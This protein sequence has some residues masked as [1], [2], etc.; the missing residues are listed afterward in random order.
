MTGPSRPFDPFGS[1]AAPPTAEAK[2]SSNATSA[3]QQS[4]SPASSPK[5]SASLSP[6]GAVAD[7]GTPTAA[8]ATVNPTVAPFISPAAPAQTGGMQ[9]GRTSIFEIGGEPF[10]KNP[11]SGSSAK[12]SRAVGTANDGLLSSRTSPVGSHPLGTIMGSPHGLFNETTYGAAHNQL[13]AAA[14][15]RSTA[16][17]PVNGLHPSMHRLSQSRFGGGLADSSVLSS[18]SINRGGGDGDSAAATV[19]PPPVLDTSNGLLETMQSQQASP[20]GTAQGG[21][22]DFFVK[23]L[24]VSRRNSREFQNLWQELE[25]F[26]IN[27]NSAHVP[28]FDGLASAEP[29][30]LGTSPKLPQGLL[31]DDSLAVRPRIASDAPEATSSGNGRYNRNPGTGRLRMG[32]TVEFGTTSLLSENNVAAGSVVSGNTFAH[33][34]P[35]YQTYAHDAAARGYDYNGAPLP[36]KQPHLQPSA[37]VDTMHGNGQHGSHFYDTS[38]SIGLIRNASTPVLNTKQYQSMQT[39][40]DLTQAPGAM[41]NGVQGDSE[42][43]YAHHP[44][45]AYSG[46]GGDMSPFDA[47]GARLPQNMPSNYPHAANG[48]AMASAGRNQPFIAGS[49]ASTPRTNGYGM[50][51]PFVPTGGGGA[52]GLGSQSNGLHASLQPHP[53][54]AASHIHIHT[55]PSMHAKPLA[56]RHAQPPQHQH[57]VSTTALSSMG[58]TQ[59]TTQTPGAHHAQKHGNNKVYRKG[60]NE[61][62][63]FINVQLEDLEGGIFEVS[64]D[65]YGCRFLQK[66]LEERVE[67]NINLI[68]KEVLPHF[69]S[70]ITD[71]FGNYL[72]QKLLEYCTEQQRT[73]IVAGVAPDLITVSLNMHGTRVVQ[74]MIESLSNQEQVDT[75]IAALSGCVVLLIRDLNGNHVIQKCLSRLSDVNNQF[76]YDSVADS[77]ADVATHRHGCCVFQR[78]IDHATPVQKSQL[79]GVVISQALSLVQDPFGNYVVQYV[80]DLHIPEYSEPLITKFVGH[81]CA[82]SLQKFSS[83]V[84]EKCIRLASPATRKLLVAPLLQ[85]DKL[86]MLM[87]DSYGNY[88]VQTA[89]DVAD[90]QQRIELIE[91]ILP[92][93]PLIRSTPYGKRIYSKLQRDG[94][95]SAIPS[96]AGSRHA[97]PTLGPTHAAHPA[98]LSSMSLYSQVPTAAMPPPGSIPNA[99]L[100]R[101]VSPL[102]NGAF[103]QHYPPGGVYYYNMAPMDAAIPQLHH[104]AAGSMV[105]PPHPSGMVSAGG[106]GAP[107]FDQA[108]VGRAAATSMAM[109]SSPASAN[110]PSSAAI[111]SPTHNANR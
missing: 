36:S 96:A 47:M 95:I 81:I 39:F 37:N 72:C 97:S 20:N 59:Q 6:V 78:C 44:Y 50:Q 9:L 110:T 71:P 77:C 22:N 86:D 64:K 2:S 29:S 28:A 43:L 41:R 26:S 105:G 108:A 106:G 33:A 56:K 10:S 74:K 88:V 107:A 109:S 83:N 27:D 48:S 21:L 5:S 13:P 23:S 8:I 89:L 46:A 1:Q 70:L 103:Q 61:A 65:Q 18:A 82:L 34:Q 15:T 99:G 25:G 93:L 67:S 100:S 79:V 84:M 54:Y 80:L 4:C 53:H 92:L 30:N 52:Y 3:K 91:A 45:H 87:R 55:H 32:S 17:A 24:P 102:T 14:G 60:D 42:V 63:R 104:G 51:G 68:F 94:F 76:I 58:S 62:N 49:G 40:D 111:A 73:Q 90:Q 11:A 7:Q 35:G 57:S 98:N 66:K 69:S 101:G 31:D 85:R 19:A 38:R 75:V 12:P 16:A